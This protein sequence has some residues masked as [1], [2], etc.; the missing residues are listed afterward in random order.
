MGYWNHIP[1]S[2]NSVF[3][4]I[5]GSVGELDL[6]DSSALPDLRNSERLI[7][8]SDYGGEHS[9]SGHL[10][11]SFIIASVDGCAKWNQDRLA[12]RSK[13]LGGDRTMSYKALGDSVKANA[14]MPFLRAADSIPGLCVT[15]A[16]DKSA[17]EFY[18]S[19]VPLDMSNPQFAPFHKWRPSVLRKALTISHLIGLFVAGLARPGQD[20][21]WVTDNDDIAANRDRLGDL[22]KLFVWTI[23]DHLAFNLRHVRCG[24]DAIDDGGRFVVDFISIA[25]LSAGAVYD[26]MEYKKR[27]GIELSKQVSPIPPNTIKDKSRTILW[28][29][30]EKTKWNLKRI[31]FTITPGGINAKWRISRVNIAS[32]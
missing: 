25:D 23:A 11:I 27:A 14:L 21:Y 31:L 20:L 5:R 12:V 24:T 29:Y 18:E 30:S 3:D 13:L 17:P 16:I 26:F 10:T 8:A 28:W 4:A 15:L 1:V 9:K 6:E 2:A 7:V 19:S 32:R 22:T